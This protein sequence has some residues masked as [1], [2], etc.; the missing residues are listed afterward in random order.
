MLLW[1]GCIA[2]ALEEREYAA[3]LA[4]AGFT[5]ISLEPTRVY[6]IDDARSFLVEAGIDVEAIAPLVE[7]KFMSAFIRATKP[8]GACCAPGCCG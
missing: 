1:V 3:K 7:G 2:G 8:G 5:G 4:Q 6:S